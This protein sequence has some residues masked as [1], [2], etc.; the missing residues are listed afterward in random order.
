[1]LQCPIVPIAL[2]TGL[3]WPR[4]SF[5]RYSGKVIVEILPPILPG[6]RP[7]EALARLEKE[8]EDAT[9]RLLIETAQSPEA[10]ETAGAALERLKARGVEVT[11]PV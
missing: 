5:W 2:N 8:V 11:A 4:N 9:N 10:P 1:E 7:K 3:F 6:L